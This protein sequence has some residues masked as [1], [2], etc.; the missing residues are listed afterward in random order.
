MNSWTIKIAGVSGTGKTTVM[1]GL[2]S[3]LK[4]EFQPIIY[5]A[6]L[7][8]CGSEDIADIRLA[9]LL[10][11]FSGLTIMDDHLEF[12]NPN[13]TMNYL[14]ENTRGLILLD[15]PL[16]DLIKRIKADNGKMR[17]LDVGTISCNL[18]KSRQKA[19]ELSN[20]TKT[21]LLVIPNLEGEVDRSIAVISAFIIANG[22]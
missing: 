21:P 1:N 15:V 3:S 17:H 14:R 9:E 11:S 20:E 4:M 13:K 16:R 7:K 22:P 8:E 10:N 2:K 5:S 6:L 18:S 12:D 19:I